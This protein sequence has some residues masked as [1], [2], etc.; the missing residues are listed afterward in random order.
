VHLAREEIFD[1]QGREDTEGGGVEGRGRGD[2]VRGAVE[3]GGGGRALGEFDE[4]AE[5]K[6]EMV[7]L[8]NFGI[9]GLVP[10]PSSS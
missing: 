1:D 8:Q 10:C 2:E 7:H 9:Q 6:E 5:G 4:V 3:N